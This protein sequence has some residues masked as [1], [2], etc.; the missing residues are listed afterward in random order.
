M[1]IY[2]ISHQI[3][4]QISITCLVGFSSE[5]HSP[6]FFWFSQP[7]TDR[8]NAS[9]LGTRTRHFRNMSTSVPSS[10]SSRN[11]NRVITGVLLFWKRVYLT[12]YALV[13][14]ITMILFIQEHHHHCEYHHHHHN[15]NKNT[16]SNRNTT[17][18]AITNIITA[19]IS[20][21]TSIN[22]NTTTTT[23]TATYDL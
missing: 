17:A 5:N 4:L 22:N 2:V 7:K 12:E 16:N 23:A 20:T 3:F 21:P 11:Y 9:L 6:L 8:N 18:F 14:R 15:D 10:E 13:P 1:S 19:T